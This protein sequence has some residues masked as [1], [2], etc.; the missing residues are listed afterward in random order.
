MSPSLP[1]QIHESRMALVERRVKRWERKAAKLG[2]SPITIEVVGE[3]T[4]KTKN[5][6]GYDCVHVYKLVQIHG[7]APVVAGYTL[8]ARVEH[9]EAGTILSHA[10][11]AEDVAVPAAMRDDVSSCDHC[12]TRRHR[13]DTFIVQAPDGTLTRCG[14]NC[15]A[16]YIRSDDATA[17]LALWSVLSDIHAAAD[18]DEPGGWGSSYEYACLRHYLAYVSRSIEL[19][20]WTS[21]GAARERDWLIATADA[22]GESMGKLSKDASSKEKEA[23]EEAQPLD[24]N[25]DEVK[26]ALAWAAQ[27]D[28]DSD[29]E[30]NLQVAT[31]LDY[32]KPRNQ[33]LVASVIAG[34]R[35]ALDKEVRKQAQSKRPASSHF[36]V[37]GARYVRQ[38]TMRSLSSWDTDWGTTYLYTLADEDG[39]VYKWFA[40]GRAQGLTEG[41]GAWLSFTV[42]AHD[43]WKGQKQTTV[44]RAKVS[45]TGSSVQHGAKWVGS[46][47]RIYKTK[48]EM[49][50][51]EG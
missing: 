40:S 36:G 3:R 38:L 21:K 33:G 35:R 11:G 17:A 15:L 51:T 25:R 27:L 39:S 41:E 23:W 6:Y 8:I 14:R 19:H 12:N 5:S 28:G 34:Y 18:E 1:L 24:H 48:K 30:H 2:L 43:E 50:V 47:G 46:N 20:G 16:D 4:V 22:A 42:K 9:T 29:Y 37:V 44:T 31:A 13:T 45:T 26:A 7:D 10:P 32:V 49:I